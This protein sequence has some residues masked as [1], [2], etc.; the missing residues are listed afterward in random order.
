[1]SDKK[2]SIGALWEKKTKN[3][4]T[5][6][7]GS[8]EIDGKKTKIAVF[9]NGYKKEDKHPDWKIFIDDYQAPAVNHIGDKDSSLPF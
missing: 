7:S 9:K 4:D 3:G 6:F 8:I 1:M 2:Q 5:L